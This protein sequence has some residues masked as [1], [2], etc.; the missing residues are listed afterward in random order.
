MI[1]VISWDDLLGKRVSSND[2]EDIG[3]IENINANYIK[4]KKGLITKRDYYIPKRSIQEYSDIRNNNLITCFS[5]QEI[6]NNF[7]DNNHV[8]DSWKV[9]KP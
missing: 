2:G 5:K 9:L 4:V 1:D 6:I 7:S 8:I 3:K